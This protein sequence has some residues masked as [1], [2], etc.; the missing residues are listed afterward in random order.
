MKK[1]LIVL[2]YVMCSSFAHTS[3]AQ[4][5]GGGMAPGTKR[6]AELAQMDLTTAKSLVEAAVAA[7]K[8]A[9]ANVAI[10]VVD[11]NGDLVYFH[12]MDGASSIAVTS[13]QGKARAA[14]LFGLPTKEVADAVAAGTPVNAKLIPAGAGAFGLTIHQGGLPIMKKGRVIGGIGAGGSSSANDE[15]FIKKALDSLK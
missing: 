9:N 7:A 1:I 15:A 11:T 8:A 12:R 10:A 4:G 6:S 5:A 14:I 13:S 2:L 3:L